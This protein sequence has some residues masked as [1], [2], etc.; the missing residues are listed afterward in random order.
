[1][2]MLPPFGETVAIPP[3]V[4][5]NAINDPSGDQA[6]LVSAF[7]ASEICDAPAPPVAGTMKIWAGP[8]LLVENAIWVPSGDQV[9]DDA[10]FV[11][12]IGPGT[13]DALAPFASM[14]QRFVPSSNAILEPFGEKD[15]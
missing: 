12:A 4:V 3:A 5:A 15:G 7:R 14:I 11:P 1:T 6:G 8:P 10:G 2:L 9:G 13:C